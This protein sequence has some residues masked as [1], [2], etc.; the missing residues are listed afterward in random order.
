MSRMDMD[1]GRWNEARHK[2]QRAIVQ[3]RT[4]SMVDREIRSAG[5]SFVT[6]CAA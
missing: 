6:I 4:A 3:E 1:L 5:G 2:L